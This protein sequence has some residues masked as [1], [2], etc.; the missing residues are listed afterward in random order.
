[1]KCVFCERELE[2]VFEDNQFQA[3]GGG[4]LKVS[5]GFGS[6]HDHLGQRPDSEVPLERL[7]AC[8][9]IVGFI[10]DDCFEK[11]H[12]LFEGYNAV[13]QRPEWKKIV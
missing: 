12:E 8:D 6:R 11:K 3:F 7:L 9:V 1:M 2:P 5:F 13:H 4:D 10:C